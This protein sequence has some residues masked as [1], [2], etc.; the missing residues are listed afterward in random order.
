M[1]LPI[2]GDEVSGWKPGKPTAFLNS[3]ASEREPM[4]S[5]DGR[6]MAY[7]S[8]ESGRYEVYVRPFGNSGGVWRISTSGGEH[9]TWSPTS[10]ELFYSLDGQIMVASYLVD[11][12]SFRAEK[13][14]RLAETRFVQR[15]QN[16]MFD[17]HP[18]GDRFVLAVDANA[19]SGAGEHKAVF[20]FDFFDE[21][22]RRMQVGR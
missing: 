16:R 14:R 19:P 20:V 17:V 3:P 2:E 12:D 15:A 22:R 10:R 6:W 1:I 8:N 13:P 18:S 9:P 4:F 21:L 7:V 5:P 11:G